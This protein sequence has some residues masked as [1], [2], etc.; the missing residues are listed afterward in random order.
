M[1]FWNPK[2]T[3]N[4]YNP[5]PF[6]IK[7]EVPIFVKKKLIK[8]V[9]GKNGSCFN[10]ITNQVNDLYYVWYNEDYIEVWGTTLQSLK[11][12]ERRLNLR[13]KLVVNQHKDIQFLDDEQFINVRLTVNDENHIIINLRII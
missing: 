10:A 5:P 8:Y 3:P 9:I 6:G 1:N 2:L 11:E 7:K 13:M 12:A 4:I